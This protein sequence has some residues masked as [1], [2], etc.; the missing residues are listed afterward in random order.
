MASPG[1]VLDPAAPAQEAVSDGEASAEERVHLPLLPFQL[2]LLDDLV[3]EDGVAVLAAGLGVAQI[4]A[5]LIRLQHARHGSEGSRGGPL[6]VLGATH[7]QREEIRRECARQE[8][9][10]AAAGLVDVTAQVPSQ[11]R[12]SLYAS[13]PCLCVTT[14][15]LVVDFLSGR[16]RGQDVAGLLILNAHRVTDA[17]GEAFAARLFR[18]A[19][20]GGA[21]RALSDRPLALAADFGR[22][23]KVLK[24]LF[25]RSLH[26]WPRFQAQARAD[27]EAA[28]PEVVELALP[29][30]AA[31]RLIYDAISQLMDA[32]VREIRKTN[33]IDATDLTVEAGLFR[34]FDE[35]IRRQLNPIWHTV[36]ARTKQ[37]V[38][39]LRTLR[40]LAASLLRFDAV[41]FLAYLESLRATEGTGSVWLFHSAAHRVFEAAKARVYALRRGLTPAKRT[42]A[43]APTPAVTI[44]PV[45]E[46]LPKWEL[47][48]EV[49]EELQELGGA[50]DGNQDRPQGVILIACQDAFTAAQLRDVAEVGPEAMMA[51]LWRGYLEQRAGGPGAP[52]ASKAAA[53]A[54]LLRQQQHQH[55][56][57]TTAELLAREAAGAAANRLRADSQPADPDSPWSDYAIAS[58]GIDFLVLDDHEFWRL[59]AHGRALRAV[60]MYDPDPALARQIELL[61]AARGQGVQCEEPI[62]RL[63]RYEESLEMDRFQASMAREREAFSSLI[64]SKEVMTA[65]QPAEAVLDEHGRPRDA[66][67]GPVSHASSL[68]ASTR[69]AGGRRPAPPRRTRLVVDLREF[70]SP[71]PGVL[72]A[73]GCEIVPLTLEVGDYVLSDA[74]CV[75]R[76]SLSDLRSSLQ[77]GRLYAQAAA[78]S[79]CYATPVLLIEFEGDRAFAL[80]AASELGD[81]VRLGALLSRIV[82]LCLHFP[83]LRLLWSRSMHATADIF[84]ALKANQDEPDPVKAAAA[85]IPLEGDP[86]EAEAESIVNQPAVDLLR[87]LPGVTEANARPLMRAAGSLAGLA[88]MSEE[89]LARVMEGRVAA[90]KLKAFLSQDCRALFQQL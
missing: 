5:A 26:M 15:I 29:L 35:T 24:A 84:M 50:G 17:S 42:S 52:P 41:T 36:G 40:A 38:A 87:R 20:P 27:L 77:S 21:V 89:E 76:K 69:V 44:E 7:W 81:D 9:L 63:L 83:R 73:A 75:E 58:R 85:G 61:Q 10:A 90:R 39:D 30:S 34:A 64:R 68:P 62:V 66:R 56:Q 53:R 13:A 45:L 4:A 32:C 28:P 57:A 14:R 47:L 22:A 3:R 67:A 2:S 51:R 59:W 88:R 82:L 12:A 6:L 1:G 55:P 16:L 33:K 25:V 31:A 19:A 86:A 71:L 49:L 72:H 78:M 11:E 80:Q 70:M 8:R 18:G 37:I 46:P 79:R 43:A 48:A 65:P 54:E 60:V 74:L 23:D